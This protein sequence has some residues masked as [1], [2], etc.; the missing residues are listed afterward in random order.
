MS[1]FFKKSIYLSLHI[2]K[3]IFIIHYDYIKKNLISII[4]NCKFISILRIYSL[5]IKKINVI[6]YVNILIIFN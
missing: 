1:N 4:D 2:C 5:L 3:R 6:H